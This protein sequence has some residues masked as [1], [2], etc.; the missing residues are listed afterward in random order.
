LLRNE[1]YAGTLHA[2]FYRCMSRETIIRVGPGDS[3][4]RGRLLGARL[5]EKREAAGLTGVE[6]GRRM[7]RA[8]S[9]LSRWESGDQI[10][11]PGDL[12][13]MLEMY[14]ISG[15]ERDALMRLAEEAHEHNQAS[16]V[17]SAAVADYDWLQGRAWK[18]ET[19]QN[20]VVPDLLQT[21]DYAREILKAWD[22]AAGRERV[23]RVLGT[24]MARQHRLSGNEAVKLCAVVSEGVL[25]QAIGGSDGMGAQLRHL[26]DRAA[27]PNVELRVVTASAGAHPGLAGPFTIMR[28]QDAPDLVQV[29]TRGGDIYFEDPEP[30]ERALRRIKTAALSHKKS[31]AMIA[32][33]SRET[34]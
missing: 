29:V 24:R 5:R 7:R 15:D 2:H 13:Y 17:V 18:L 33:V 3:T 22:P 1:Q 10:P 27:L 34:T 16:E 32:A 20:A 21:A 28:F 9:S 25:R 23:E 6:V 31:I 26:L 11:R 12:L 8:H 14:G 19:F 30:F 4:L